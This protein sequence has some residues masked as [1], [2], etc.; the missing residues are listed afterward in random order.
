[1]GNR[2]LCMSPKVVY[3]VT[4]HAAL[5]PSAYNKTPCNVISVYSGNMH[6]C[7]V[8]EFHTLIVLLN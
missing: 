7:H 1:M 6:L 4:L 5:W 8:V 3:Y 2:W